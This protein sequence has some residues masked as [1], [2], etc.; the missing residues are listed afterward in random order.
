MV[1]RA[2]IVTT[3]FA[4]LLLTAG[5]V[6]LLIHIKANAARGVELPSELSE[7]LAQRGGPGVLYFY[8]SH[9]GSCQQQAKILHRLAA[10]H[11]V[12]V[13]QIDATRESA[14]A[15]AFSVLSV[16]V[17]VVFDEALRVQ[18]INH[19]LSQHADL[20]VQL[21]LATHAAEPRGSHTACL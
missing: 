11:G 18:G 21:G 10:E 6:K 13:L 12:T 5:L 8:G 14:F 15:S 4:V 3:A 16:P 2:L 7:R 19:G 17:T 9:C 20:E 1:E